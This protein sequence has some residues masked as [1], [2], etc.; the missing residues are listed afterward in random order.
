MSTV[1]RMGGAFAL[2]AASLTVGAQSAGEG[3]LSGQVTDLGSA[4]IVGAQIEAHAVHGGAVL[5]SVSDQQ[6]R[7]SFSGVAAGAYHLRAAHDGFQEKQQEIDVIA[8]QGAV[9]KLALPVS[10]L[11]QNVT[12]EAQPALMT[13]TPASQTQAQVSREDF[14]NSPAT[15]IADVL[16][17]VPGVTFVQGNGPRDVAVSVRGA[18][19]RQIYGVRNVQLFEDGFPVTQPDGLGRTD[20]TDPHAYSSIDVVEGPSSALYGNYATGGAINFHTRSGSE[21]QGLEVGADFGSFGYYN[22]YATYG[23]GNDRYQFSGFVSNVRADQ[24]TVNNQYNTV[25]V[26][27]LATF[28]A[29]PR[30][31]MTFKFINNDLDTNLSIRLSRNQYQLNPYQQG[32]QVYNAGFASNGCSSI[33][34]YANGFNG[35]TQSLGAAQ[36]GLNRHDRRTIVGAR[37]EHDLTHNTT[38]Q[39]Q[40]VW[41]NR[42]ANQPTSASAYRGTLPSFNVVSNLL[43][44]GLFAGKQSTTYVAGSFNYENINSQSANLMPGG[45]AALGG[46]TQI[47]VG[48]HSNS[49]FRV[50]EELALAER[51]VLVAGLG[52]EYTAL[53]ALAQNYTYPVGGTP[54][55]SPVNADRTFF[56]L[57]PEVGVQFHPDRALR[58]HARLGTGYG[59]PQAT[60]LFTNAQGQFGNNITLKTQRN[61]GVDGGADWM[62]GSSL[63][64]SAAVF[65]EWFH[66][67]QVTQSPGV[68]LQSYTFNAPASAH[69]GVQA[70]VDWHPLPQ[71]FSGLRLRASYLYDNQIY[72]DYTEQLTTG[73]ATN[74]F[75]RSGNRIPGVQP[76]Y[77]NARVVYDQPSGLMRGFG[78]YVET[79]WRANYVLDNANLLSAPG[80]TLWNLSTHYDP[81]A[82]HGALSRLR[83][84]F[85]LQNLTNKTYIASAGNLTNSLN[86][87]GQQNGA[88]VLMNASGSIYAGTPRAS[89]GGV[90]V[91]F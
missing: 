16:S 49:G 84:F 32:C 18:S 40:F 3:V 53:N 8:G 77:L 88:A 63:Q 51:W 19:N 82:G 23:A 55:I 6:G 9:V 54:A 2:V 69:R 56:N 62:F 75:S 12:V 61:I 27:L 80:Y 26:N 13:E 17:L 81:P 36:A 46:T 83:F 45:K 41:D 22:D 21:I 43:R 58:L 31:R 4:A 85:D 11:T 91:R 24:A 10:T 60:Q 78:A 90:R 70:S 1:W 66:N 5:H 7:F 71:T 28:A 33:S 65:Y 37:Y 67:E 29:T 30:D 59:T 64:L 48:T 87:Q 52:G 89:Y 38:W 73:S 15:T 42:D 14:K 50:R 57:A 72:T 68:N 25:T 35:T 44:R 34:V 79:N 47:V 39:T 20:L 86:A 76:H 74:S